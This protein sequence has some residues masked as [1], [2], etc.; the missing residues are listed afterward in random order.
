[1]RVHL[2][3][4]FTERGEAS[5]GPTFPLLLADC[6]SPLAPPCAPGSPPSYGRAAELPS[7]VRIVS[8]DLPVTPTNETRAFSVIPARTAGIQPW[9][10]L[11]PDPSRGSPSL[12]TWTPAVDAGVTVGPGPSSFVDINRRGTGCT[13]AVQHVRS[14]FGANPKVTR[15]KRGTRGSIRSCAFAAVVLVL[16]A[17]LPI[18]S[19]ESAQT[20]SDKIVP[21]TP[22]ANFAVPEDGTA[23][24]KTTGLTWMRCSLGQT[25]DGKTCSGAAATYE[26][27]EALKAANGFRFAGFSDWRLPN[28]NELESLIEEACSSPAVN[29]A[30]FPDTPSS[31]F[32]SS[33]PYAASANGAWS[34]DF[35]FGA[36]NASVK[37]GKLHVRLVRGGP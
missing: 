16:G 27:G 7:R 13:D 14:A 31:Y 23:Y 32:W 34:V 3:R 37:T 6:R 26:W 17:V 9:V 2:E 21:T 20:C 18:S 10:E 12:G 36:V 24:H 19:A 8:R 11:A 4:S 28:K 33:S 29:A 35:G 5:P 15:G 30:V 1:M 25:W 22:E